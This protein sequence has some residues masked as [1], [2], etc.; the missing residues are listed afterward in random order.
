MTNKAKVLAV[1]PNAYCYWLQTEQ[2][3]LV[4]SEKLDHKKA[5]IL[6]KGETPMYAWLIASEFLTKENKSELYE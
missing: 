2:K 5:I 6:G 1:Y 3:Y 4:W